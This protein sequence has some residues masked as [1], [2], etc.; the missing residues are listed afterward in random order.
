[1]SAT[2]NA[3]QAAP[4]TA[5]LC[6]FGIAAALSVDTTDTTDN[7]VFDAICLMNAGMAALDALVDEVAADNRPYDSLMWSAV[8]LLRQAHAIINVAASTSSTKKE[9]QA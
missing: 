7:L 1:M 6:N 5:K 2:D 9:V 8:Y 3:T 4:P